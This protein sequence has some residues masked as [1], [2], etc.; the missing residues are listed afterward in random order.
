MIDIK[1]ELILKHV[2]FLS[3]SI[4][5][6]VLGT[7]NESKGANYVEQEIRKCG[8]KTAIETFE[9][10]GFSPSKVKLRLTRPIEC[11]IPCVPW[12]YSGI[13]PAEGVEAELACIRSTEE[14][15]KKDNDLIGKIVCVI[16]PQKNYLSVCRQ[17]VRSVARSHAAGM[18]IFSGEGP[19]RSYSLPPD[20]TS[21]VPTVSISSRDGQKLLMDLVRYGRISASLTVNASRG[22]VKSCNVI[23]NLNGTEFA[24]QKVVLCAHIDSVLG[25]PG[26]ND[27]AS[28]VAAVLEI[29]RA[30]AREKPERTIEFVV[31]GAEE[32]HPYCLGS[33]F[34][35]SQSRSKL[36]NI[37]AVL[38]FDMVGVGALTDNRPCLKTLYSQNV[39]DG[40]DIECA[41]WLTEYI[42]QV[43]DTTEFKIQPIREVAL[44]D[45]VPLGLKGVPVACFRWMDDP[46]IHSHED[47]TTNIDLKK[48][49]HMAKLGGTVAWQLANET[50]LSQLRISH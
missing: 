40:K 28:G 7:Q 39:F 43:G 11:E 9:A 37:M 20:E 35:V 14:L 31:F 18:V 12:M 45:H 26:A 10:P 16:S 4:G 34:Y 1:E 38:N 32:P 36:S 8:L 21:V 13:T 33:R 29:A 30:M 3:D 15:D 42:V 44:S 19:M 17:L 48:I 41:R 46:W 23:G 6:R 47:R 25:S 50:G 27:N 5:S 49:V 24:D 22:R 2:T